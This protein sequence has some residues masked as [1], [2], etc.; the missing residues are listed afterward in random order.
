M[1]AALDVDYD[2]TRSTGTGAAVVPDRW[3]DPA[4][5]VEYTAPVDNGGPYVPDEFYRR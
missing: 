2:D 4:P 1:K 3:D 5:A